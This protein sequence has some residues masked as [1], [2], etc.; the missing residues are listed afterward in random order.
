MTV[1]AILQKHFVPSELLSTRA[2]KQGLLKDLNKQ[3]RFT[4]ILYGVLFG[5]VCVV[6]MIAIIALFTD[7]FKDE[8][9][10]RTG[11]I[12]GAG[13]GVPVMLEW[14]R[15]VVR[16]WTQMTLLITVVSRSDEDGI[17]AL[18]EKLLSKVL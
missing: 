13:V 12:A 1:E 15:R 8:A 11:I 2:V 5:A 17:Q 9:S 6:S 16:E 3:K 4:S 14:M 10:R 7:V 18:L